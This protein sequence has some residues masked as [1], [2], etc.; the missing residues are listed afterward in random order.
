MIVERECQ[1][2]FQVR[3][4]DDRV[5]IYDELFAQLSLSVAGR[6]S[7][8]VEVARSLAAL[9]PVS[10]LLI[11]VDAPKET[12][13]DRLLVRS[14]KHLTGGYENLDRQNL[15]VLTQ[16]AKLII[17]TVLPILEL[18]GCNVL[19]LSADVSP[20]INVLAIE[21]RIQQILSK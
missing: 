9:M 16:R 7:N 8:P 17:S 4:K 15:R 10:D 5:V 19:K 6:L 13:I 12:I 14:P 11:S 3:K 18:R 20:A 1:L 21:K 2:W